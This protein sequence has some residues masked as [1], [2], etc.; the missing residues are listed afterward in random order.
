MDSFAGSGTTGHSVLS[1]N[2][3]DGGNR[4]FI[5]IEMEPSIS[6]TIITE[7]IRKVISGYSMQK[8]KQVPGTGGSFRYCK[9]GSKLFHGNGSLNDE[10]TR[11]TLA[12]HLYFTEF[13]EPPTSAPPA[14]G[15][16]VGTFGDTALHLLWDGNGP[17]FFDAEALR[18]LPAWEGEFLVYGE[19]CA[20]PKSVLQERRVTFRQ[21]PYRVRG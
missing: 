9:L 1:L 7:R 12:R 5:L 11:D 14:E 20:I 8:Q 21:I 15:T 18:K 17:A 16:L 4:K 6:Q 10:L 19:G 3:S 2:A 13:G